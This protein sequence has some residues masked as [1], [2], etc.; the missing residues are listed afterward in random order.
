VLT[1]G[2][3]GLL[4]F[5]VMLVVAVVYLEATFRFL[6]APPWPRTSWTLDNS[7]TYLGPSIDTTIGTWAGATLSQS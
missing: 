2:A 6:G 4:A 7:L 1:I 5:L 3:V